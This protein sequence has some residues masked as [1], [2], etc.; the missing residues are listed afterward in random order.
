MKL[1]LYWGYIGI[2]EKK[3]KTTGIICGL[4]RDYRVHIRVYI[5]V[6][7]GCPICSSPQHFGSSDPHLFTLL[8]HVPF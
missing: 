2:M 6:I 1:G 3:M 5:R 7:L 8:P 4:Y